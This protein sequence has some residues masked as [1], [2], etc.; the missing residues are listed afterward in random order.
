MVVLILLNRFLRQT[1]VWGWSGVSMEFVSFHFVFI[2][3]C[4]KANHV[5]RTLLKL[6]WA[7]ISPV[8]SG[9]FRVEHRRFCG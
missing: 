2:Y 6:S 7:P 1:F 4:A 8:F 5:W 3:D 9:T